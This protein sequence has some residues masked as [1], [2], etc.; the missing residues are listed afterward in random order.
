MIV[1]FLPFAST[2]VVFVFAYLV[3]RRFAEK[4]GLHLLLW[5]IG[6]IMYGLGT[7]AEAILAFTYSP[8]LIHMWYLF[9]AI[10]TPAW[11]GQGTIYLLIR[12]AKVPNILL[13]ILTIVTIFAAIHIYGLVTHDELYNVGLPVQDGAGSRSDNR[14]TARYLCGIRHAGFSRRRVILG[15]YFLAQ[16]HHAAARDRQRADRGRRPLARIGRCLSDARSGRLFVRQ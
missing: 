10:L 3:L 11:L 13:I 6:L 4:G 16:A 12:R 5:G 7:M 2:L 1:R 15:L 9:G 8:F 14:R